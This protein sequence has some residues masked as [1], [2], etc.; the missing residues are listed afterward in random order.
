MLPQWRAQPKF[1]HPVERSVG[2]ELDPR[3]WPGVHLPRFAKPSMKAI[4]TQPRV[5][6]KI[7]VSDNHAPSA[8]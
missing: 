3:T 4:A 6:T 5:L 1:Q 8:T 2:D 7:H